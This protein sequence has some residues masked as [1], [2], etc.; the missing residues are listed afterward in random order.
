[1]F[2]IMDRNTIFY[3]LKISGY[4][5]LTEHPNSSKH[6]NTTITMSFKILQCPSYGQFST[7]KKD[8]EG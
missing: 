2:Q 5:D 8:N 3:H 6:S 1:M 4:T 7:N